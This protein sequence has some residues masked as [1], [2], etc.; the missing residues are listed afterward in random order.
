[1]VEL[2]PA[3]P[4]LAE[5]HREVFE[6]LQVEPQKVAAL[7]F[8]R[9][10]ESH[11]ECQLRNTE[12]GLRSAESYPRVLQFMLTPAARWVQHFPTRVLAVG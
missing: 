6:F 7:L 12:S 8:H 3:I 4:R 5:T 11:V 9:H 2:P 10:I 1:M